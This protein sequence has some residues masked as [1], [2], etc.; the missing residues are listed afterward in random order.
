MPTVNTDIH[1]VIITQFETPLSSWR[2]SK[3]IWV[4]V[5]CNTTS[6]S[7]NPAATFKKNKTLFY[8]SRSSVHYLPPTSNYREIKMFVKT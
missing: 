8:S 4:G 6:I 2:V 1:T 7:T 3:L 5:K